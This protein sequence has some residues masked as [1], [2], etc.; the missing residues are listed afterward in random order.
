MALSC[1][2]VKR[3]NKDNVSVMDKSTGDRAVMVWETS[4]LYIY[5]STENPT[6]P[7]K[8][9][10]KRE[11]SFWGSSTKTQERSECS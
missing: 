6:G 10:F 2:Q 9:F 5:T 1:G 4:S 7:V 3:M 8:F 11:L